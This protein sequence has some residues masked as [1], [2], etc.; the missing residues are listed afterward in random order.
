M[1]F[2]PVTSL[3][4]TLSDSSNSFPGNETLVFNNQSGS[5][6]ND[7]VLRTFPNA[8]I[9]Y[10]G[11]MT[12]QTVKMDEKDLSFESF[13]SDQTGLRIHLDT[14]L[15]KGDTARLEISY[16]IE[17]P[18][19]FG[20]DLSYGIYN[21]S[22]SGPELNLA[23]WYPILAVYK[24]GDWQADPVLMGGDAV[25][26]QTALFKVMITAPDTWK[27]AS[28]GTQIQQI[29]EAGLSQHIYVSGPV[30][31]F[32]VTASP[33]FEMRQTLVDDISIV[34]WGAADTQPAWDAALEDAQTALLFYENT[35]GPYPFNELDI[36]A[37][38][39][40]NASGV[41]YPGLVL[42]YDTGYQSSLQ[43]EF[44]KLV[45]AHE[46][47]HQW[48]YSIVG[49]DVLHDPWMDEALATY[50]SL[51]FLEIS[52]PTNDYIGR[53]QTQV[54]NYEKT[55]P[56][57]SIELPLNAFQGP[58]SQYGLVVYLKG[59]LFFNAVRHQIGDSTFKQ[60]L[61]TYY[62]AHQYQLAAPADLLNSFTQTCGCDLT[63]VEGDY[64]VQP[65]NP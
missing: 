36:V 4:L 46:I 10:N 52:S 42:I 14:P 54:N 41:E 1:V 64:G 15:K 38:K 35:F 58:N 24:N 48:W 50:S 59:A 53:Y 60:A 65:V 23:N 63:S 20:S 62:Q 31:D 37:A 27:I 51:M 28:T 21:Q 49:N 6:L 44:L 40:K 11:K 22:S 56:R 47:A 57:Q 18:L 8:K 33:A 7:I 16:T 2:S 19:D 13:L 25:T 29:D 3:L 5:V 9:I 26:S 39:L 45:I 12:I 30:R 32:M 61:E 17:T 43:S 34:Q 55:N